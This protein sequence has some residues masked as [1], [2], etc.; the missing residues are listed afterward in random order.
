MKEI[1]LTRGQVA[2]VDDEDYLRVSALK[3]HAQKSRRGFYAMRRLSP[4]GNNPGYY[5]MHL[6]IFGIEKGERVDHRDGDKLN[7][8]KSNLRIATRKQN[9]RAF[10][11]LGKNKTSRF[12]GVSLDR[13]SVWR[14]FLR[15]GKKCLYLGSFDDETE[16]ARAYDNK[17]RELFGEFACPNFP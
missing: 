8:Q 11:T 7:N 14:A 9:A 1:L 4:A 17:A 3:W 10:R 13:G 5:P 16:A 2:K 12:R 15:I 6:F